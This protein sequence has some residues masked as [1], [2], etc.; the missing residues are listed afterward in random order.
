MALATE[1]A[2]TSIASTE[3]E[4]IQSVGKMIQELFHPDNAK[5][6]ATLDALHLD[7]KE[8]K[9]MRRPRHS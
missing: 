6:N 2:A 5:V 4:S 1:T 9:K 8:E 3:H 7:S